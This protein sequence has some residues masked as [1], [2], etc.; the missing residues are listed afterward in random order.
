MSEEQVIETFENTKDLVEK[1]LRE[2]EE[3][4]NNDFY[5]VYLCLKELLKPKGIYLPYIPY[6]YLKEFSGITETITRARRALN[7]QGL[8]LPTDPEVVQKRRRKQN[9]L[10]NYFG[11]QGE[12][13]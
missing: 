3:A 13:L 12:Q 5:L 8:Y 2:H 11:K 4:R 9:V 1:V 10:K 6:K 7:E